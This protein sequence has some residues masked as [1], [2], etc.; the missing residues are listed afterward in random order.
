MIQPVTRAYQAETYDLSPGE[1]AVVS[2]INTDALDRFRTVIDP[3]GVGLANY[4][5]NPVLLWEHGLDP[6]RGSLPVGR[7]LWIKCDKVKRRL[8]AKSQYG[9]DEFSDGLWHL[10][11]AS[12]LRAYSVNIVP[13]MAEASAPSAKELKARS[14]LADCHLIY[15]KSDLAEYSAVAVPGNPECLTEAVARGLWMPDRLRAL[16]PLEAPAG[17]P[18]ETLLPPLAGR[19]LDEAIGLR[20]RK[21]AAIRG[22]AGRAADD[23]LDLLRGRI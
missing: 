23:A 18:A 17:P 6:A 22:A 21:A 14:D 8:I 11:Q 2:V 3:L 20:L 1:R 13:D 10:C 4:R 16:V 7:N 9:E 5:K 12:I 15:R 19:R